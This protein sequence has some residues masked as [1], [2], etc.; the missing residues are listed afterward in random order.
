MKGIETEYDQKCPPVGRKHRNS[1]QAVQVWSQ[2]KGSPAVVSRPLAEAAHPV[3]GQL[4]CRVCSRRTAPIAIR[5]E[6]S[7]KKAQATLG[8]PLSKAKR[9]QGHGPSHLAVTEIGSAVMRQPSGTRSGR[10]FSR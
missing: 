10:L 6:F 1:F 3:E 7:R 8:G 4:V 5:L 9:S 2:L